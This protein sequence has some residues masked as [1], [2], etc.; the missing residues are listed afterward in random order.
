M[1]I[2]AISFSQSG[3]LTYCIDQFL[4][5]FSDASCTHFQIRPKVPYPFP[6]GG[7]VKF[8]GSMPDIVLEK[9]I[10]LEPIDHRL[11]T[12]EF[13]L[14]VIGFQPWFLRV[15]P[16]LATF[17]K[18][19]GSSF[20]KSR[21]V[22]TIGAS[23]D[24][25]FMAQS[26]LDELIKENGSILRR[27]LILC[28]KTPNLL[29]LI[30]TPAWLVFGLKKLWLLPTAGIT[31]NQAQ[32]LFEVAQAMDRKTFAIPDSLR[33][34][35]DAQSQI[36]TRNTVVEPNVLKLFKFSAKWMSHSICQHRATRV[37]A[38]AFFVC[39]FVALLPILLSM[40]L[41]AAIWPSLVGLTTLTEV[42][43]NKSP[44]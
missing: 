44:K 32:K 12:G 23:R 4:Q 29:S 17:L 28:D 37:F 30:T 21:P 26:Q 43:A 1:K 18:N 34:D 7:M 38:V 22:I 25:W 6:W 24:M 8:F 2:L 9:S 31:I 33:N 39:Y 11:L 15:P 40:Q 13:D 20:L 10:E 16:P 19:F 36:T 14:I 27:R 42:G 35:V 41:V 3:Q 5:G